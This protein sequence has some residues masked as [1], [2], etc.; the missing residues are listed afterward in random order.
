MN[1]YGGYMKVSEFVLKFSRELMVAL[2]EAYKT[3]YEKGYDDASNL[4]S[5]NSDKRVKKSEDRSQS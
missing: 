4:N 2:N 3:G 1:I 5:K